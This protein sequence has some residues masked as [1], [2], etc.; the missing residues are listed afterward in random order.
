MK[1]AVIPTIREYSWGAPGQ[2]M[3]A[4]VSALHEAGHDVLWLVA[5]ID[6]QH[7][8]VSSLASQGVRVRRLPDPPPGY[9][10]LAWLRR[11]LRGADNVASILDGFD[12]DHVFLNQGGTWCGLGEEF[13]DTLAARARRY[14]LICHLNRPQAAF[15]MN[16]LRRARWLMSNAKRVF[17]NSS[18]TIRL[19]EQQLAATIAHSRIFQYPLRFDFARPLEWPTNEVPV[20]EMLNRLDVHHKGIDLALQAMATLQDEGYRFRLRMHGSGPDGPYVRELVDYLGLRNAVQVYPHT[21]DLAGVWKEAEMLVLPS[22]YEGLAVSML[23]AMGFGRVVL[24]TPYGGAAEWLKD[25]VT[26]YICPAAEV[27]ELC[28]TL[29]RALAERSRWRDMGLRAHETLRQGRLDAPAS[30]FLEALA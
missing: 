23:E 2:C 20:L 5:P 11:R 19:A 28:Q 24:R 26:G 8:S 9:V 3:G 21:D 12:P 16:E 13:F 22:R 4:L 25:G 15:S 29:R 27:D 6:S 14:S 18:W 10:R 30:V 17:A 1:V 7:P